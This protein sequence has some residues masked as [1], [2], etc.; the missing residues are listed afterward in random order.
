[1]IAEAHNRILV[2]LFDSVRQDGRATWPVRAQAPA[3]THPVHREEHVLTHHIFTALWK[4]LSIHEASRR[5]MRRRSVI[6]PLILALSLAACQPAE[7]DEG[8]TGEAAISEPQKLVVYSGRS[9]NLAAPLI[10]QFAEQTGIDVDVRYGGAAEMA[11]TIIEEGPNSPAD[12][13]FGQDAGALG[14]LATSERLA[15]L[16]EAILERVPAAFRSPSGKWVGV[17]GR[18]RVLVYDT[19]RVGESELPDDIWT[20]T[21]DDWRGRVG[22]A[23]TNGSF[24]SFVTALRVLEGDSQAEAWLNAMLENEVQAF[25]NNT[26]IV[27]AVAAGE[28]GV[29][30]VNHYYLYRFLAEQGPEFPARN[31]NFTTS[32]AGSIINVAGVGIL[33]SAASTESAIRFVEFLLSDEAQAYFASETREYPLAESSPE[34][35]AELVPLSE[36]NPPEL[37]L[38]DLED[39]QGTLELLQLSGALD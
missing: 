9:E 14:A 13:F 22:W 28:I 12:V 18:A 32:D 6:V 34:M 3:A 23:P 25:P 17:S 15:I 37:D 11:A 30:L 29:G 26:A 10:E 27:D 16:P 2:A 19:D 8:I 33:D 5:L 38:S 24:Q 20:L 4:Q 21:D 35:P 36:L 1:M 7:A 31:Y 39:L